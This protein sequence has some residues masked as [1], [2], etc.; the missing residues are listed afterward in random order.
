[1][2][3]IIE[4]GQA[5]GEMDVAEFE[6]ELKVTLP[7]AYR[8]FLILN[9]GGIPSL[10]VVDIGGAPGSPTDV[11]V[12][13]GIDRKIESSTLLWNLRLIAN[14]IHLKHVLP[15]ACD[16]GGNLFCIDMSGENN[17]EVLY[18]DLEDHA[19]TLYFVASNFDAFLSKLRAW[20]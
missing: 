4:K 7:D 16:S 12:F 18:C 14:R 3:E 17:G 9:N 13:F 2:V 20:I 8:Q 6:R 11:Q 19:A 15:I 1:M 10:N 5:I